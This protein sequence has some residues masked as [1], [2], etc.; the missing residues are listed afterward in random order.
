MTGLAGEELALGVGAEEDD[1][2]AVGLVVLGHEAA[3]LDGE[4]AEALVLGPDAADGT[5]GGVP[6]ADFGDGAADL[7][8][9][10][11]DERRRVA[12]WRWRRRW[13]GGCRGRR[14]SPGLG[15]RSCRRR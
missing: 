7:G 13:S 9:D 3:L 5:A 2:R 1:A 12:G 10:G 6:L 11:L 14:R 15:S 8:G 4:R